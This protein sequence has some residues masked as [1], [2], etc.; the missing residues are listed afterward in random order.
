MKKIGLILFAIVALSQYGCKRVC[1]ECSY[2]WESVSGE[3]VVINQPEFCGKEDE[4]KD[5]K[6]QELIKAKQLAA[7]VG[8]NN[9]TLRCI[10]QR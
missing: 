10:D 4:V 1:T 2:R 5:F 7:Q 8:G 3:K 6:E 9:V